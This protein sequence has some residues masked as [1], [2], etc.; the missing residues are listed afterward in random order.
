MPSI[1]LGLFNLLLSQ[2]VIFCGDV[3]SKIVDKLFDTCANIL[4]L[5]IKNITKFAGAKSVIESFLNNKILQVICIGLDFEMEDINARK[6]QLLNLQVV[7]F[8]M[9]DTVLRKNLQDCAIA[10]RLNS[11]IEKL[12]EVHSIFKDGRSFNFMRY[13][14]LS[15]MGKFAGAN[16]NQ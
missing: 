10:F 14:M 7:L 16:C 1:C 15:T 12:S 2:A 3:D 13:Q 6:R 8:A 9:H 4:Q 5:V 11:N